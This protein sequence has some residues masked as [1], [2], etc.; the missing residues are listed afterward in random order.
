MYH[1]FF[2]EPKVALTSVLSR[3]NSEWKITNKCNMVQGEK[4]EKKATRLFLWIYTS[5][6]LYSHYYTYLYIL[7]KKKIETDYHILSTLNEK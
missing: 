1:D 7:C 4:K 5:N 2:T 6:H 3:Y